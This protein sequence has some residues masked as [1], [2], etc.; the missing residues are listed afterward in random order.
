MDRQ[1]LQSLEPGCFP[2][3]GALASKT[4]G[5][6]LLV[7]Q[8][9]LKCRNPAPQ[10]QR[11]RR[12]Q[13]VSAPPTSGSTLPRRAGAP[14]PAQP[15]VQEAAAWGQAGVSCPDVAEGRELSGVPSVGGL[16]AAP[17]L[18]GRGR[19]GGCGDPGGAARLP[20]DPVPHLHS[21]VLP[22]DQSAPVCH[23]LLPDPDQ[24]LAHRAHGLLQRHASL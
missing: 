6:C 16:L 19:G 14:P 5:A 13:H 10:A 23:Q 20:A 15:D 8:R 17:R 12:R 22:S 21:H 18:P 3:L 7:P 24:R 11:W 2:P 4:D 9:P 1:P